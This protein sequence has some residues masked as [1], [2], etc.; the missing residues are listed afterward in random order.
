M[1][2]NRSRI[3]GNARVEVRRAVVTVRGRAGRL[4][5]AA[6]ATRP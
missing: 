5:R 4:E 2:S 3:G 6:G 1:A